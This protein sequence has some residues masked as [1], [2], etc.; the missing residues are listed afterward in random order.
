M[1]GYEIIMIEDWLRFVRIR[2]KG[3]CL[4]LF[5]FIEKLGEFKSLV[6]SMNS[7]VKIKDVSN[8][9]FSSNIRVFLLIVGIFGWFGFLIFHYF[10]EWTRIK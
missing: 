6:K 2:Y 10:Y 4:I 9:Y 3:G 7:N 8:W 1:N 5:P